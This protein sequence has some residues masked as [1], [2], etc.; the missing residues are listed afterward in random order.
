MRSDAST[1]DTGSSA[2]IS[3]GAEISARAMAMRCNCP[4][5]SSCG[6]RRRTSASDRPTWRSALSARCSGIAG[7]EAARRH[8]QIAIDALQRIERLE[9]VLEDRLHLA[10]EVQP[11]APAP[12]M[13]QRLPRKRMLPALGGTMLR[14][15]RA[16]VV[17]PLPE[18]A[19]DRE[20]FRPIAASEKLTPSTARTA[21]ARQQPA[22]GVVAADIVQF[23]QRR[24][25]GAS[26]APRS[27][28]R[29]AQGS[30]VCIGGTSRRQMSIAS[31]QRGWKRQPA[32][33]VGQVGRRARQAR[34]RRRVADARQAGDQMRGVGMARRAQQLGGRTFL[35]QPPGVHHAE[36]VAEIGVHRE[37]MRDEQQ[38]GADLAAGSRGSSPARPSA[39]RHRA[40]WSVRRR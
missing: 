39:R 2:T 8:E 1:I 27:R 13:A 33:R 12:R 3:A 38:R 29:D 31:G 7:G 16:S 34:L 25:H 14:I 17:L 32:R 30:I 5:D 26:P 18:F 4:P 9:R 20:D 35:H 21:P 10:H 22:A 11:L 36:P 37:I 15:M 40:R 23:E 24:G 6:K 28:R 19:D